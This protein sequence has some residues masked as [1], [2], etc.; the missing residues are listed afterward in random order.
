MG[1]QSVATKVLRRP[2][3]IGQRSGGG[4]AIASHEGA[5]DARGAVLILALIYITVISM[6][7]GTLAD[8]AM[9]DLNN[10]KAFKSA[11]SMDYAVSSTVEVA[12]QTIRYATLV[13][14]SANN[15]QPYTGPIGVCWTPSTGTVS[16]LTFNQIAVA[17]WCQTDEVLVSANTRTVRIY[18]CLASNGATGLNCQA[19]ALLTAVEVFDDY[20]PGGSPPLTVQCSVNCGQGA[21]LQSWIWAQ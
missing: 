14:P 6:I 21:L 17:V 2:V 15:T 13:P 19:N 16:Q 10:T 8:W 12:I 11:R 7:V 4:R 9:N 3:R 18:A 20:S 5:L 1:S